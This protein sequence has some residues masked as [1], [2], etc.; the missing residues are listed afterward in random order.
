MTR[1][2]I[3][4]L[5][6]LFLFAGI[7]GLSA[8]IF[9]PYASV[10]ALAAILAFLLHPL[11]E[12]LTRLLFG[13]KP[14]AAIGTI[15]CAACMILL[16]LGIVGTQVVSESRDM[17]AALSE[18]RNVYF[19]QLNDLVEAYVRPFAPS[20]EIDLHQTVQQVVGW[21]FRNLGTVFS[22]TLE[23]VFGI[24]LGSVALYY[25]LI[26][27]RSF[28]QS[29]MRLSPL[30][31]SHDKQILDRLGQAVTSVMRGSLSVALIQGLLTGIG[32]TL[33]GVPNA[34]LWGSLAAICALIPGVGTSL[35]LIPGI[36]FLFATNH[37]SSA[38]GLMIW[39]GLAVGL[40]DN[41]LGPYL[42][43]RGAKLHPLLILFS[44]IGGV[45]LFG[46]FGFLF[47]PL[48]ISLL[49]ALLDIYQS[50][51]FKKQS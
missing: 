11:Y 13:A 44:V 12:R 18:N 51:L 27:G 41:L 22:G 10:L 14:L 50:I 40:I 48:V 33:F 39:G 28:V 3:Q 4:S 35:I 23:A 2:H 19:Q 30:S 45:S 20:L 6:F 7:F 32:F 34:A 17:Y 29:F 1:Q 49:V 15:I 26:D 36:L 46:A 21:V 9:F 38:V 42:V 31:D 24:V 47:G 25:F 37:P 43:G 16:P 8:W 5:F